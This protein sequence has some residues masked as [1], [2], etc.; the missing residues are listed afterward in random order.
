VTNVIIVPLNSGEDLGRIME[1]LILVINKVML[2]L[3]EICLKISMTSLRC[4]SLNLK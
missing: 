2:K 4:I 1:L 3:F